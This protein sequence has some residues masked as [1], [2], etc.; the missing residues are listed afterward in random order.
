MLF[1]VL[2]KKIVK[3]SVENAIYIH[4]SRKKIRMNYCE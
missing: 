3:F 4:K 1:E 2:D